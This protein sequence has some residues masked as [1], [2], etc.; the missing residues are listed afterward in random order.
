M[1]QGSG[2]CCCWCCC[3]R[4]PRLPARLRPPPT[5]CPRPARP[6]H[7]VRTT[8]CASPKK[9]TLSAAIDTIISAG[10]YGDYDFRLDTTNTPPGTLP[11]ILLMGIAAIENTS[12]Q[13]YGSDGRTLVGVNDDG[14]CDYGLLQINSA[15][16]LVFTYRPSL[17]SDTAGNVAA[18]SFLF[19]E[20]W[21]F[22]LPGQPGP[23][24]NDLDPLMPMNWLYALTNY[25][26]GPTAEGWA[27]NPNCGKPEVQFKCF[28]NNFQQSHDERA[29]PVWEWS[30]LDPDDYP[31]QERVP[32]N[33]AFPR[34]PERDGEPFTPQWIV[35]PLGLRSSSRPGDYGIRPDDALFITPDGQSRA[36]NLL[37]FRHRAERVNRGVA[38]PLLTIELDL[39]L[40]ANVTI[41]VLDSSG[42]VR[43]TPVQNRSLRAGWNRISRVLPI[44]VQPGDRY[45]LRAER[46]QPS[47]VATWYVGQY[48]QNLVTYAAPVQVFLPLTLRQGGGPPNLL[49][50]GSFTQ[51]SPW[52]SESALP[53]SWESLVVVN[54]ANGR[55]GGSL[56]RVVRRSAQDLELHAT[57]GALAL[58]RQ[59]VSPPTPGSYRLR[60]RVEA[61]DLPAKGDTQLWLRL[62]PV[63]VGA[64][65]WTTLQVVDQ[66]GVWWYDQ[67]LDLD[68]PV[69]LAL[70]VR[71]GAS[72]G[73][74]ANG[75]RFVLGPIS[76]E[77]TGD[78]CLPPGPCLFALEE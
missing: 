8:L 39:P 27:N 37:L 16:T 15:N 54:T 65:E 35:G 30:R 74:E 1:D 66:A 73:A 63:G 72:D 33:L 13:Q 51:P 76:L 31:Y 9:A 71:F 29:N 52:P 56:R 21:R 42:Q 20:K 22:G 45:R 75:S 60:L 19:S 44:A 2:W 10:Q 50:N 5:R 69:L 62:R 4:C 34:Y 57:P 47:T 26:G 28:E 36:P 78:T 77:P 59:R 46:G 6:R 32:Y 68:G 43:A 40:A 23:A 41:E 14:S 55:Y 25:N 18:G 49:R 58:F 17:L 61:H 12:W 48:V 67:V 24:V 53:A 64:M 3:W 70:E 38:H 11:P 7:L